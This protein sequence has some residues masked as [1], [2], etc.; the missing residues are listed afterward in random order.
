[1]KFTFK[2]DNE[3]NLIT[4]V[5]EGIFTIEDVKVALD[6]MYRSPE[7]VPHYKGITDV[8]AANFQMSTT[9]LEENHR[10]VSSHPNRPTGP[11]AVVCETPKQVAHAYK[12]KAKKESSHT[13]N[14]F[15]TF[16]AAH[17]WLILQ[18]EI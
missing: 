16:E 8:R 7:Y 17:E 14:V 12:Y 6:G 5:W 9:D 13:T 15:S 11:W 4:V 18:Y 2:V 3:K 10:Y 1:M